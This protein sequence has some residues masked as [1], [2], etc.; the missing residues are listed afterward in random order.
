MECCIWFLGYCKDASR[1][2]FHETREQYLILHSATRN[3]NGY[4]HCGMQ[5]IQGH[6]VLSAGL[7][8]NIKHFCPN[9][10]MNGIDTYVE[11][12]QGSFKNV[13]KGGACTK[14]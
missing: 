9:G 5:R 12:I 1:I 6:L 2:G 4:L 7:Q 8:N 13:V 10:T 14:G 3:Q 11:H